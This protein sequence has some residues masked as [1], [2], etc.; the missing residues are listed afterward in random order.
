MEGFGGLANDALLLAEFDYADEADKSY[1]LPHA[2]HPRYPE[3]TV[4]ASLVLIILYH[5]L[6][7][8]GL[9]GLEGPEW[10]NGDKVNQEPAL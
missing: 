2:T 5:Y 9:V 4:D 3:E 1:E 6:A 7:V 8:D 10:N